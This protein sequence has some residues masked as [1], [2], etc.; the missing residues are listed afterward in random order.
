M[1]PKK[2][3]TSI[4]SILL[5]FRFVTHEQLAEAVTQQEQ[6]NY[7]VLI[8]KILIANG[9]INNNQLEKALETQEKLRKR[10]RFSKA[11]AVANLALSRKQRQSYENQVIDISKKVSAKFDSNEYPAVLESLKVE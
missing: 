5:R 11:V 1:L 2:D 7:D 10:D 9:I 6:L 4:G 3:P 8:G